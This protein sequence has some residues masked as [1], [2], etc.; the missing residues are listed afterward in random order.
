MLT[1]QCLH[2]TAVWSTHTLE[3]LTSKYSSSTIAHRPLPTHTRSKG[4]VPPNCLRW[5]GTVSLLRHVSQSL[6]AVAGCWKRHLRQRWVPVPAQ[7]DLCIHCPTKFYIIGCVSILMHGG[8]HTIRCS[9]KVSARANS[10]GVQITKSIISFCPSCKQCIIPAS[11]S[12]N[13][14]YVEN[15]VNKIVWYSLFKNCGTRFWTF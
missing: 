10:A 15:I 7:H 8:I 2:L 6:Q 11:I 9:E 1:L 14:L 12:E 13:K 3:T 4:S 5:S